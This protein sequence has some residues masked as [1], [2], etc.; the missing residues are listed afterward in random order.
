LPDA[1]RLFLDAGA[2]RRGDRPDAR[3]P[4]PALLP[5]TAPDDRRVA[6]DELRAAI[7]AR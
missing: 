1:D 7:P 3:G 5:R 6:V 4:P 2:G